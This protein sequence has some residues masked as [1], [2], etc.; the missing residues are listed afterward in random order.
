MKN[1]KGFTLVE[2]LAVIVVL[3]VITVIGVTTVLPYMRDAREKAFRVEATEIIKSAQ[4]AVEL[5][6]LG[7]LSVGSDTNSCVKN[8][9]YCF[10]VSELKQLAVYDSKSDAYVG[11]VL[12]AVDGVN[13]TYTLYVKKSNEFRIIGSQMEDYTK[14]GVINN[15]AW[16]S[17]YESCDCE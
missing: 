4:K 16:E 2:L 10:T 6:D 7:E 17:E 3:A 1:N 15:A 8:N 11:K 13:K 5:A 14:Y 9:T 12:V